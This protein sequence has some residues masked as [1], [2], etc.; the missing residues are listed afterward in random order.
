MKELG[1]ILMHIEQLIKDFELN[2]RDNEKLDFAIR[3][4]NSRQVNK[5]KSDNKP[6]DKQI[7]LLKKL[8]VKDIDKLTKQEASA[9]ID[10]KLTKAK[11]TK[12]TEY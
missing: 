8:K 2:I 11:N 12:T 9:I 3:I 10:E 7:D 1:E 5:T 6:T 4:Y